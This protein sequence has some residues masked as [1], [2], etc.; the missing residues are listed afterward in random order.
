MNSWKLKN[1]LPYKNKGMLI[2][3]LNQHYGTLLY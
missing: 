3:F 1:E 2:D